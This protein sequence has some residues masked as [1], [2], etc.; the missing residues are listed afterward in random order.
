MR[1][2]LLLLVAC[3]VCDPPSFVRVVAE[4]GSGERVVVSRATL[5][6]DDGSV[7]D[8]DCVVLEEAEGGECTAWVD[9]EREPVSVEIESAEGV[10]FGEHFTHDPGKECATS[11]H[12]EAV[13]AV[14]G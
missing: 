9:E 7:V 11:D 6:L 1:A 12:W 10:H 2:M 4:N 5:R 13:V 3:V 14:T 8:M